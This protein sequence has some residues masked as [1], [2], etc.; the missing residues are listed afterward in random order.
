MLPTEALQCIPRHMLKPVFASYLDWVVSKCRVLPFER[1]LE[2][3]PCMDNEIYHVAAAAGLADSWEDWQVHVQRTAC[4]LDLKLQLADELS[5]NVGC[6]AR[7][8]LQF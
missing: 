2:I 3:A 7:R 5:R 4:D 8:T 6:R 1:L